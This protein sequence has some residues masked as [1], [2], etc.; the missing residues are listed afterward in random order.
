MISVRVPAIHPATASTVAA[1]MTLPGRAIERASERGPSSPR[2]PRTRAF[3][4]EST[5]GGPGSRPRN[6]APGSAPARSGVIE[7]IASP[8]VRARMKAMTIPT[9]RRIPNERTIGTGES[10]RTRKPA[11]VAAHAVAI[12][13]PPR[14]AASAAARTG[15]DPPA[16]A[17]EKRA[18]SW[19]A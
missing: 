9:T 3:A 7:R 1:A 16:R 6:P 11:A 8:A 10:R 4:R 14:A 17:S 13:G 19:I 2:R 5:A 12:T 15:D 18:C